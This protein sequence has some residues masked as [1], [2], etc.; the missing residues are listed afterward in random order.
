MTQYTS[1]QLDQPAGIALDA[2]GN[3]FIADYGNDVV[4]EVLRSGVISTIAGKA[5]ILGKGPYGGA[6]INALLNHPLAVAF[7]GTGHLYISDYVFQFCP[8]GPLCFTPDVVLQIASG[9]ISVIAGTPTP[10]INN[11][12][13]V[14]NGMAVDASGAVSVG[15]GTFVM[16]YQNGSSTLVA[17]IPLKRGSS[18]DHGPALNA[19][20]V[21]PK[22]LSVDSNGNIYVA[23]RIDR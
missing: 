11:P 1:A 8:V 21:S 7:D 20:F 18:G 3:L 12:G 2:A 14:F 19:L 16:R 23:V 9:V 10:D 13:R 15:I 5:G 22:L 6:A 4:R 17:G